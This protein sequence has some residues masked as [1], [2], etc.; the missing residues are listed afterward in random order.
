MRCT[1]HE[2]PVTLF[3]ILQFSA[4]KQ[5]FTQI[6]HVSSQNIAARKPSNREFSTEVMRPSVRHFVALR[7]MFK[8][9]CTI[10]Y[11][12]SSLFGVML[13]LPTARN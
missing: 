5:H 6:V 8:E 1:N 13:L 3:H 2:A 9:S 4:Y 12:T 11:K 10:L 7:S